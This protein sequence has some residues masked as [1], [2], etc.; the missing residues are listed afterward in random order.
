MNNFGAINCTLRAWEKIPDNKKPLSK[1]VKRPKVQL[2]NFPIMKSIENKTG[3]YLHNEEPVF[4]KK[5]N[6]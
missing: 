3:V 1:M 4:Y 2:V 6:D 5:D